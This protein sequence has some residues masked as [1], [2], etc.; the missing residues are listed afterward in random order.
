MNSN[1]ENDSKESELFE[2]FTNYNLHHH[3]LT[4][5]VAENSTKIKKHLNKKNI[6]TNINITIVTTQN[7]CSSCIN[8][9]LTNILKLYQNQEFQKSVS[10]ITTETNLNYLIENWGKLL[11]N[12]DMISISEDEIFDTFSYSPNKPYILISNDEDDIV[13]IFLVDQSFNVLTNAYFDI[14]LEK[15]K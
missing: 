13:D 6:K 11:K 12:I 9:L 1:N 8:N 15:L 7:D 4:F 2:Y 3:E 10:I 5:K 14:L